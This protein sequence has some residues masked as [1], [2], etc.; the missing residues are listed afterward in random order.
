MLV[1]VVSWFGFGLPEGLFSDHEL[2]HG[3]HAGE[4]GLTWV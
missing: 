2:R 1:V 3:L 4:V